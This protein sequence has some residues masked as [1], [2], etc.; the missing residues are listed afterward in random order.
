MDGK[1]S[2]SPTGARTN[3][4]K[5]QMQQLGFVSVLILVDVAL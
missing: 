3:L 5:V 2:F 1:K 4:I